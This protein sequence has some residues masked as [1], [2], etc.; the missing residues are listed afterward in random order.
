MG[1]NIHEWIIFVCCLCSGNDD[2]M[3]TVEKSNETTMM[4]IM[5]VMMKSKCRTK[6]SVSYGWMD[7]QAVFTLLPH[8]Y[9]S[10]EIG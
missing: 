7:G 5:M 3:F 10:V 4:I 9:E 6:S 2:V 1:L 8:I